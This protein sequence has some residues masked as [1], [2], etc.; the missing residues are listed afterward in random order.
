M[1]TMMRRLTCSAA[2]S[3]MIFLA[4]L[5][6]SCGANETSK[7]DTAG[8][9]AMDYWYSIAPFCEG[10]PAK[11]H[12]DD[13]DMNL[14]SGLLCA[15][16]ESYACESVA[17]AQGTDGR[18][19][20]SPRRVGDNLGQDKTFSRDMASGV[21]L[22]LAVTK[23][24]VAAQNWYR[25]LKDNRPCSIRHPVNGGCILWGIWRHCRDSNNQS[26]DITPAGWAMIYRLW[27]HM[28][29]PP[30]PVME[31]YKGLDID[32]AKISARNQETGYPMHLSG[33]S[34]LLRKILNKDL[35]TAREVSEILHNRQPLNPFF[36]WLHEGPTDEV[37]RRV[38]DFCPTPQRP[39]G[40]LFQWSW[41][42]A[43]SSEAW[44]DSMGWDCIFMGRLL[45]F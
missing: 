44:K 9:A 24:K 8:T 31:R 6:V 45:G 14:F 38:L 28:G 3:G 37:K 7:L 23:D 13:G 33:V 26:C 4:L 40:R 41:E 32:A 30:E 12:C 39:P 1:V 20:R 10:S 34:M 17:A 19:W 42:R 35:G 11:E 22:Y 5:M 29:L 15:A 43:D 2:N 36:L 21:F 18:W 27:Q 25:W 16:G